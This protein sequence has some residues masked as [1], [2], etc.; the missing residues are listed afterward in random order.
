VGE[1]AP[2]TSQRDRST[3]KEKSFE[4]SDGSPHA[5]IPGRENKDVAK[6]IFFSIELGKVEIGIPVKRKKEEGRKLS[7]Q[8]HCSHHG[9]I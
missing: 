9:E 7:S 6:K 8:K 5:S 3:S 4:I 1:A 2:D